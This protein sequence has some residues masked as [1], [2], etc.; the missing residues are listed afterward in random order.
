MRALMYADDVV[1]VADSGAE[2]QAM[3]DVEE[4]HVSRW[5]MKFKSR[6]SKVM[7]VGKREA[8]VSWKIGEEIVEEEEEF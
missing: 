7:V 8:R 1:L 3:V 5:K 4:A 6:K 2:L